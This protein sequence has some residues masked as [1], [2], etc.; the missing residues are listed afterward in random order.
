MGAAGRILRLHKQ[1]PP[2]QRDVELTEDG[3]RQREAERLVERIK[4][5]PDFL[6]ASDPPTAVVGED[7]LDVRLGYR[8]VAGQEDAE[9]DTEGPIATLVRQIETRHVGLSR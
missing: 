5:L 4:S 1:H 7:A 6:L 3:K 8:E 2:T 9:P